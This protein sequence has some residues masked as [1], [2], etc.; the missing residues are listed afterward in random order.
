MRYYLLLPLLAL[1]A[2][3]LS[4][5]AQQAVNPMEMLNQMMTPPAEGGKPVDMQ[6]MM[7][8]LIAMQENMLAFNKC[9]AGMD[10][11]KLKELE[12]RALHAKQTVEKL[13]ANGREEEAQR[14]AKK[15]GTILLNDPTS[16]QLQGCSR[17]MLKQMKME[18][19]INQKNLDRP[20]CEQLKQM[21]GR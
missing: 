13:C 19:L 16:I 5:S 1:C 2:L 10:M 20:V 17:D 11:E 4:A 21:Q 3:P 15:E 14:I 8:N 6:A 18:H 9:I 7:Q 12:R